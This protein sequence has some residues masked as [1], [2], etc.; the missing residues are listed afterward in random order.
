M[1]ISVQLTLQRIGAL[2]LR[3]IFLHYE[4]WPRLV[5]ML[6]WPVINMATWGFTSLYFIKKY[7]DS[8]II[9]ATLVGAVLLL[10]IY[11][12]TITNILILFLEEI[13]SRNLGHLFA[14]PLSIIEY[15]VSLVL[16]ALTRM[17]IAIIPAI[18]LASYL[19]NF[20]LFSLGLSLFLYVFL[21]AFNACWYGLLVISLLL[22]FGL[23]A[24]WLGWMSAW[25]MT[26]LLAPYY[27]VTI[28]PPFLQIV[29][30]ALPATYVF[31]SMKEQMNQHTSHS[32]NLLIAL[33]LNIFYSFVAAWI[34]SRAYKAARNKG[35]LLQMGE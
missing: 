26:P 28:L 5:E 25:I 22:R 16:S 3:H 4:S 31:E 29:A 20:S 19:F 2:F 10:E 30:Y 6:Y 27:P 32:S 34:L 17:F 9:S 21:L 11:L 14:S 8:P 1:L 35:S 15:T 33:L 13:W 12:R 7:T 24:E 18:L 23:A